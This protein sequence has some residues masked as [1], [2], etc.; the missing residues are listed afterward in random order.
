[1]CD[2]AKA[3]L[4]SY[5]DTLEEYDRVHL[6]LLAHYRRDEIEAA[7]GYR[8]MLYEVQFK[9]NA[10]RDQFQRHQQS[11]GCCEAMRFEDFG[12]SRTA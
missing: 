11:H 2:E 9:L 1:M 6:M 10:A 5:L 7:D 4:L 3:L 12:R 8:H